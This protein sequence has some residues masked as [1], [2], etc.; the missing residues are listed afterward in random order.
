ML[1]SLA[2][3][4]LQRRSNLE[5]KVD[6]LM[7][8]YDGRSVPGASVVVMRDGGVVFRKS[9]GMA[10]LEERVRAEPSTNYRLA[11]M[12]KQFT[13]ASILFLAERGKLSIDDPIRR[14]LPELPAWADAITIR[15]LLTHT[16]GIVD[17]EDVMPPG[18]TRQLRDADVLHLLGQQEATLFPPGTKYQYSNSGYAFL[19]LIVE[20]ASDKTFAQF[21]EQNV[22][23]PLRMN[24]AVAFEEGVSA[25]SN[26]AYGYSRKSS[27]AP[28]NEGEGPSPS[29]HMAIG[30]QAG[31]PVL[32]S[33]WTRTD[34]SLTSA[35][36]GDGG[37]YSSVDDL[38][39]WLR[40]LEEASLL[41]RSSLD[42]AFAPAVET[43]AP[44]IR[45]GFGWRI[46]QHRGKRMI[47]HT[48][49]TIGFRNAVVR[50]P[51]QHL[52]VAVLTNR[53]E[54]EPYRL[55]VAIADGLSVIS[56]Q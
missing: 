17:Y 20:R 56:G 28:A 42:L 24:A 4:T 44:G 51:D 11:S 38:V 33:G 25:V 29:R 13:A 43:G 12:T 36:L 37:I 52:N 16:S 19:A 15:Q 40:S 14:F 49:E 23:A 54:G 22:F 35:V 46:G 2:C 10:D 39:L 6:A 55:A 1:L 5:T 7:H 9:Y 30:G 48:G 32:H 18:L 34:Q 47:W 27:G 3:G 26:R 8:D 21:L 45:Y 41:K 53:N 50:F 31:A